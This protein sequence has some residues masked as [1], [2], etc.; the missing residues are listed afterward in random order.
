V[1]SE[2]MVAT[3]AHP[4]LGSYRGVAHPIKFGRTPGP[5]PF[6]APTLGQDTEEVIGA[7]GRAERA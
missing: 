1:L 2:E 7:T 6:A 4:S 5:A 3:V